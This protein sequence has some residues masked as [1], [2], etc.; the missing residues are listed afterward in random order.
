MIPYYSDD[1]VTLFH[2][3]ALA[4]LRELPDASVDCCVTSPPYFGLRDYGVA[5]QIGAEASPAEFVAVL[6]AVFAEVR[7]VLADDGTLW[8][9]LGDSYARQG[10]SGRGSG[11]MLEGRKHGLAQEKNDTRRRKPGVVLP[12]KNL[13]GV[14][15]RTAFALQ[16][17]GWILRNDII[18]AKPNGMPE[19]VTDRLS[20]KHEHLFLF[21]KSRRYWFDLDLIKVASTGE[22]P[23]N[24]PN[25]LAAYA[26]AT[27]TE[28]GA[29]RWGGNPG[30][31]LL[32]V[33]EKRNPGDVWAIATQP[34][35]EAHF[36]T[37]PVEIPRRAIAA[38]CKPGGIVLDPFSG[39][40]TT[41]LAAAELGR[42]YVGIDLNSD[43][44]DLSLR[45]RLAQPSALIQG[46]PA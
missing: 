37:F 12:E 7:R 24:K 44:L 9:N 20:T 11:S 13:L 39:S 32:E 6:V 18:W 41:G 14:P 15:W 5:G 22:A 8:L 10:G 46:E 30:S 25:T 34:F 45:T 23:G 28:K 1:S 36:A 29:R 42:R 38:G 3:D 33:H 26:D 4:V 21:A 19:S 43:Y 17:D 40:G 16:D 27:G 31:T 35:S 2:G